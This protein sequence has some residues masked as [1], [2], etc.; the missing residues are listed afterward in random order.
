VENR[1]FFAGNRFLA[2]IFFPE[3]DAAQKND[4]AGRNQKRDNGSDRG[5]N[6][7]TDDIESE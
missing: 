4:Q 1:S 5:K 7:H 2:S 6:Q 3:F